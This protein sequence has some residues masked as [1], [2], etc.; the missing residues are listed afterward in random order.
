MS[1]LA[2]KSVTCNLL[3]KISANYDAEL[4]DLITIPFGVS[5]VRNQW[6]L[7]A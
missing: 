7:M 1:M 3:V 6:Y 4:I 2:L 5:Y